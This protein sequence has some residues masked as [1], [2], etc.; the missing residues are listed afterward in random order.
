MNSLAEKLL[1]EA[2]GNAPIDIDSDPDMGDWNDFDEDDGDEPQMY[3]EAK[4]G[5]VGLNDDDAFMDDDYSSDDSVHESNSDD[6]DSQEADLALL[7]DTSSEDLETHGEGRAND[8]VA[9]KNSKTQKDT[10]ETFAD[11]ADYKELIN[12]S[13][14][15]RKRS[16]SQDENEENSLGFARS[17]R[18]EKKKKRRR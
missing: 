5:G 9:S 2:A 6:S 7:S 18:V 15:S 1:S 14:D 16:S 11:A 13:W 4:D 17:S 10:L 12:K 3:P 8:D